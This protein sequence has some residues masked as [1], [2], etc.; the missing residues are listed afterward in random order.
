M[1]DVMI[2]NNLVENML[3]AA[4]LGAGCAFS[5]GEG[6]YL[7][8]GWNITIDHNTAYN[9]SS[10]VSFENSGNDTIVGSGLTITNNILLYSDN[11]MSVAGNG[12]GQLENY[13][14]IANISSG[15]SGYTSTPNVVF[16][17]AGGTG[18]G[19]RRRRRP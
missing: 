5:V 17:T 13:A 16:G 2:R 19:R 10:M 1:H 8:P 15:G 3:T 18:S 4:N 7:D 11:G 14:P 12:L 9:T 6:A